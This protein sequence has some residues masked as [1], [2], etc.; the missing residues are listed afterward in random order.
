MIK[1]LFS[2]LLFTLVFF[3]SA[4]AT[5]DIM[6][7]YA[8]VNI[9]RTSI[10][11]DGFGATSLEDI[12]NAYGVYAGSRLYKNLYLE[13]G[14]R[15][16]GKYT[17]NY[18]L[19]LGAFR[20]VENHKLNFSQNIYLGFVLRIALGELFRNDEEVERDSFIEKLHI[21]F[22]LGGLLWRTEFEMDGNLYDTGILL[23]PY[24]AIGDDVGLSSYVEIGVGYELNES[25]ILTLTANS[26]LHVGRGAEMRLHDGSM[27]EFEGRN[28]NTVGLGIIYMF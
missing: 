26:Y 27:D 24:S 20:F 4:D 12:A 18:D 28:I 5:A 7:S 11:L 6:P 21:H 1:T 17:A 25:Y 16:L 14:Y 13:Y 22:S 15:N 2:L 23:G 19:T 9:Q 8:G 3:N 10:S